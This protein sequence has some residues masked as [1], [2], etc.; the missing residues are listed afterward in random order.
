MYIDTQ[1][2]LQF[3]YESFLLGAFMF[4]WSAGFY[5]VGLWYS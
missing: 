2:V 1:V 5:T 4:A 3:M